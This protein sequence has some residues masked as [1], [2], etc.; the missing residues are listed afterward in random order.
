MKNRAVVIEL[1]SLIDNLKELRQKMIEYLSC[2]VQ[3]GWLINPDEGQAE[4]Y[5]IDR[6]TEVID[7][8]NSLFGENILHNLI[9]DLSKIF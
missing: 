2:G 9:V 3:L 8:P 4:T 7:H 1:A 6:D 5:T